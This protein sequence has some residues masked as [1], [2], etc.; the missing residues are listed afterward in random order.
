MTCETV[1]ADATDPVHLAATRIAALAEGRARLLVAVAGPPA[2]GKSTIAARIADALD[3][4]VAVPMDGYHLD[5]ETLSARGLL[6]RKGAPETFDADGFI[7]AMRV[8]KTG[9]RTALPAFDRAADAT[10]PDA[11]EVP[12]EARIVVV[13]GN[14]LCLDAAPWRELHS[15][16]DYRIALDVPIEEL[17]RRLT[18]RWLEHGHT[19]EDA[20]RRAEANDLP[21]ARR[22]M[23]E[24]LPVDLRIVG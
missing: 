18:E 22:V 5:N 6:A 8:L 24:A 2:S 13:E 10:V 20:V 7:T 21:N 9:E 14:Y 23:D 11:I 15:L 4:A 17:R 16:W 1:Y 19:H 12:A 3:D